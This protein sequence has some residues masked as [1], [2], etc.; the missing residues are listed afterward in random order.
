MP[1]Y[2][3]KC[4]DCGKAYEQIRRMTEADTGLA[5]PACQSGH[6]QRLLSSF[7]TT[8]GSGSSEAP[9]MGCGQTNCCAVRGGGCVN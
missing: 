7:A 9:M 6:V 3:Y 5:C 1:I 2:E 8:S 4:E